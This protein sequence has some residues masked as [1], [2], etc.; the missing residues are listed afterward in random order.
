MTERA[1][2]IIVV[3]TSSESRKTFVISEKQLQLENHLEHGFAQTF[4]I[5]LARWIRLA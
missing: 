5:V 3:N 1:S 4:F 2:S